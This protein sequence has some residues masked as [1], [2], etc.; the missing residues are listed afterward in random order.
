M[1]STPMFDSMVARLPSLG[2]MSPGSSVSGNPPSASPGTV[3]TTEGG[4]I[5][6]VLKA[7]ANSSSC[8]QQSRASPSSNSSAV[9]LPVMSR[10][11]I[12]VT[13][14]TSTTA[15]IGCGTASSAYLYSPVFHYH[16]DPN[17]RSFRVNDTNISHNFQEGAAVCQRYDFR[18]S[19]ILHCLLLFIC[20]CVEG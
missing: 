13:S 4:T 7:T 2:E 15:S 6:T 10:S 12:M 11:N 17:T 18:S 8:S 9:C 5:V 3:N 19:L 14:A 20:R 16:P 1:A